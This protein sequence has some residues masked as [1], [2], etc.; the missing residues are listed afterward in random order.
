MVNSNVRFELL[1]KE[2]YIKL[3][4]ISLKVQN[5]SKVLTGGHVRGNTKIQFT[6][7]NIQTLHVNHKTVST[8]FLQKYVIKLPE[9]RSC[10]VSI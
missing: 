2:G 10:P 9:S 7:I 6:H 1:Q 4:I 5:C 3:R 8:F